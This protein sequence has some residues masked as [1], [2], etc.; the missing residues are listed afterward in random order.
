MIK[1]AFFKLATIMRASKG[2]GYS[3]RA[4]HDS[5]ARSTQRRR[6]NQRTKL[7]WNGNRETGRPGQTLFEQQGR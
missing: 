3:D 1:Q 4:L 7:D 2:A 5:S 6:E